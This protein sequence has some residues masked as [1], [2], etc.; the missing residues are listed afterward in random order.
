MRFITRRGLIRGQINDRAG[1]VTALTRRRNAPIGE[2]GLPCSAVDPIRI[3]VGKPRRAKFLI[4]GNMRTGSTWLETLLGALPDVATEYE[5]KWRPRY[6]PL[7]VHRVL[8]VNSPTI[9]QILEEFESDSP[10]VGSKLILDPH[11]ISS[12]EFTDLTAKLSPEIR[13]IHLTRDPRSIFLSRRR[14]V[15]HQLNRDGEIHISKHLKVAIE[16]ADAAGAHVQLSP[17]SVAEPDC[18]DELAIYVQNDARFAQLRRTHRHYLLVDYG[19][20]AKQLPEIARFTGSEAGP[21]VA[22]AVLEKSPTVKLPPV[23]PEQLVTNFKELMP[24]FEHFEA[25]RRRFLNQ[26]AAPAYLASALR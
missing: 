12:A 5:L 8:D 9:D 1:Q 2:V 23:E 19:E 13:V 3:A 7:A 18:Y 25:L 15:Y 16:E 20:I 21:D 10:I 11:H 4:V 17:E 26:A 24:F 14:G 22:A 6:A